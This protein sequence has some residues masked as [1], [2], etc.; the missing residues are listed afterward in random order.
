MDT[1][2]VYPNAP[3]A[4]VAVEVRFLATP[5]E[6]TTLAPAAQRT[7]RDILGDQWVLDPV[8]RQNVLVTFSSA[9]MVENKSQSV[10]LP[11]FTTRDRTTAVAVTDTSVTIET[12][13]YRHYPDFRGVLEA[14]F[15]ATRD[16]LA[17]DGVARLG[18]RYIDEIQVS[19]LVEGHPAGWRESGCSCDEL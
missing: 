7:F 16:V 8:K 11:R 5:W 4:L 6:A 9:G 17:P 10:T 14:V 15:R 2:E 12:T 13:F 19:E 3:L 18:M 1:H